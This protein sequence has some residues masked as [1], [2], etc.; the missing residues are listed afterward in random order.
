MAL[1]LAVMMKQ[2]DLV[3]FLEKIQPLSIFKHNKEVTGV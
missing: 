1:R 2:R 3:L